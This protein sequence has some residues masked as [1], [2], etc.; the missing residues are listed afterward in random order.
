MHDPHDYC[1]I[2]KKWRR[3]P[4]SDP[5]NHA[6][7]QPARGN[8]VLLFESDISFFRTCG[9]EGKARDPKLRLPKSGW[10]IRRCLRPRTYTARVFISA[11]HAR[12]VDGESR[13]RQKSS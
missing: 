4:K 9:K 10:Q 8:T 5:K 11:R 3:K 12:R 7:G 2:E 13:L 1:A 6:E